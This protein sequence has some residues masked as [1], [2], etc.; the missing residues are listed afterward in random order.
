MHFKGKT[1][2]PFSLRIFD[3]VKR[4]YKDL[5]L[6]EDD[7]A[8]FYSGAIKQ[9]RYTILDTLNDPLLRPDLNRDKEPIILPHLFRGLCMELYFYDCNSVPLSLPLKLYFLVAKVY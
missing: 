7:F 5:S 2:I 6:V 4:G 3:R 1:F 9:A 8:S